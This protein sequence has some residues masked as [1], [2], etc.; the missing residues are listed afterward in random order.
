MPAKTPTHASAPARSYPTAQRGLA[1][2]E[3]ADL[4]RAD[5]LEEG[6]LLLIVS[7]RGERSVNVWY[8]S[9]VDV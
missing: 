6:D 7:F 3:L 5:R 1:N 4:I 9:G 2:T 8:H